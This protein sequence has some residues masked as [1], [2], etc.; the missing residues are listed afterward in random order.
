MNYYI[1]VFKSRKDAMEFA[2][3]MTAARVPVR[4]VNTPRSIG[5]ACGISIRFPSG[6]MPIAERILSA[7]EYFG[8]RGFYRF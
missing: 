1:A 5:E 6:A 8:F 2:S 4:A 3:N 7:G